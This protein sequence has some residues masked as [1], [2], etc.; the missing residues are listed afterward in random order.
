[1][2]EAPQ[3]EVPE[4]E[5]D[6]MSESPQPAWYVTLLATLGAGLLMSMLL[7]VGASLTSLQ[8]TTAVMAK[9]MHGV[10]AAMTAV[11]KRL[12]RVWPRLRAHG[13]NIEVLKRELETLCDCT[14]KLND[15]EQF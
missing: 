9:E 10:T 4:A 3:A 5:T 2:Y 13:E 6:S 8:T 12:T 1:M 15:P 14:I 11:D 7:W